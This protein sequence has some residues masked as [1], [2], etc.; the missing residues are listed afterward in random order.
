MGD[1]NH[2]FKEFKIIIIIKDKLYTW[3]L[4]DRALEATLVVTYWV[5]NIRIKLYSF[6]HLMGVR[7]NFKLSTQLSLVQNK[8]FTSV[9][10]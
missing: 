10:K 4:H 5:H 6:Y 8:S 3:N 2:I 7:Q 1:D 9:V